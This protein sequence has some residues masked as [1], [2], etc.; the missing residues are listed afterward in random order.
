MRFEYELTKQDY[1]DFNVHHIK[2][3]NT[4]KKSLFMQQYVLAVIYL[5]LPFILSKVSDIP[6]LYWLVVFVIVAVLWVI[7]YP[8]YFMAATIKRILKLV[9]EGKNKDML[10]K[11]ILTVNEE[12]IIEESENGESRINW[13][14]VEKVV[15]TEKHFF[16]YFSSIMAYIIP[17]SV[18]E[19]DNTK[20]EFLKLL[21]EKSGKG[22]N[23]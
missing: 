21:D 7:F 19:K 12:G 20:N 2:N 8:K 15:E 9:D 1:I 14:G 6:L 18:F 16:I 5:I 13:S 4:L 11:H 10:G 23:K 17:K 22:N 3:S